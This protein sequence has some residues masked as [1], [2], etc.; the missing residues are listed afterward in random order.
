MAFLIPNNLTVNKILLTDG[1]GGPV[2]SKIA[3]GS[4]GEIN[5]DGVSFGLYFV[6]Y[7]KDFRK[8]DK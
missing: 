4:S 3:D 2:A 7:P 6:K 5:A 1:I 8:K